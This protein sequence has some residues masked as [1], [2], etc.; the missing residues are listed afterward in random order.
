MRDEDLMEQAAS[1]PT[2]FFDGFGAYRKINGILRCVGFVAETGA[3]LN[4]IISLTGAE[5]MSRAIRFA[6][7]AEPPKTIENLGG[8]GLVN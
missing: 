2:M 7:D 5:Q 3:Q 1:I 6:L 8:A 4:L